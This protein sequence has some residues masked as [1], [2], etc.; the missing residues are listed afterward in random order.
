MN[1]EHIFLLLWAVALIALLS[2]KIYKG[3]KALRLIPNEKG[4]S[5]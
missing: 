3:K 1:P 4:G 2:F 5:V